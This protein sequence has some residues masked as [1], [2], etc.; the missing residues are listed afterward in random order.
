M[1]TELPTSFINSFFWEFNLIF[2]VNDKM[3]VMIFI[4]RL[5][6]WNFKTKFCTCNFTDFVFYFY[7]VIYFDYLVRVSEF[8][9]SKTK[10]RGH[11][12]VTF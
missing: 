12:E 9:A 5:A 6:L 1:I 4:L 3:Y 2:I 10:L 8:P 7:F 11:D